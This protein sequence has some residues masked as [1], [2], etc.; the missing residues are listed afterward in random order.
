MRTLQQRVQVAT[1][2]SPPPRK[3]VKECDMMIR[4]RSENSTQGNMILTSHG[5]NHKNCHPSTLKTKG[6]SLPFAKRTAIQ[7]HSHTE[8]TARVYE[9]VTLPSRVA[10]ANKASANT[11]SANKPPGVKNH[12]THKS[13]NYTHNFISQKGNFPKK[14]ILHFHFRHF[15]FSKKMSQKGNSVFRLSPSG[16]LCFRLSEIQRL[17]FS[18]GYFS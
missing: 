7:S 12:H 2:L 10:S 6:C 13:T 16:Q 1:A 9:T 5:S 8:R 11:A 3:I 15:W 4:G 18:N 17:N 14:E